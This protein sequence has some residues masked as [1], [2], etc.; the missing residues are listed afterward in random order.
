MTG[1]A[2]QRPDLP[3]PVIGRQELEAGAQQVH[4]QVDDEVDVAVGCAALPLARRTEARQLESCTAKSSAEC[5]ANLA[6]GL[7]ADNLRR[8]P[9]SNGGAA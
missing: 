2:E 6:A 5:W 1:Q 9:G 8:F 3:V 7:A 4:R